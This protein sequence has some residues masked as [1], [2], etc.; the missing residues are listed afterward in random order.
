M[1][2]K[3]LFFI[4]LILTSFILG[5]SLHYFVDYF[6]EKEL[7][8]Q[9]LSITGTID[10]ISN[11]NKIFYVIPND[12]EL[13]SKYNKIS[14]IQTNTLNIELKVGDLI[15]IKYLPQ[16]IDLK[17][18][19]SEPIIEHL[20]KARLFKS[21]IDIAV[22]NST[23]APGTPVFKQFKVN[24]KNLNLEN[25]T[26][27]DGIY[28]KKVTSYQDYLKYK[29]ELPELRDLTEQ[30]F[31]NYYLIIF[32]SPGFEYSY[33]FEK[34]KTYD[35]SLDLRIFKHQAISN[36]EEPITHTGLSIILPNNTDYEENQMNIVD[37]SVTY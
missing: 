3:V 32:I 12:N 36:P 37:A 19:I 26:L 1:K 9:F 18:N 15:K 7:E 34:I 10:S 29:K 21:N 30:D 28:L 5:L 23:Y 6:K 17:G 2:K 22:S 14:F 16:N 24:N 25:F 27:T 13:K 20:G 4:I 8:K 11:D 31:V 35:N 33:T